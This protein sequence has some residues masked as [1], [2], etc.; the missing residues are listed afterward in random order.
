MTLRREISTAAEAR[1][2]NRDVNGDLEPVRAMLKFNGAIRDC[3]ILN[4]HFRG[5]GIQVDDATSRELRDS[6][7]NLLELSIYQGNTLLHESI[8]ARVAWND[9]VNGNLGRPEFGSTIVFPLASSAMIPYFRIAKSIS[10]SR[11]P[12][13][14][15]YSFAHP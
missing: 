2:I 1:A 5:M 11:M 7:Q 4:F 15:A 6:N 9:L 14:Q 13:S 8:A 3:Q 12:L 10:L